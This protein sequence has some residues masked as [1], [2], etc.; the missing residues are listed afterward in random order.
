MDTARKTIHNLT[1]ENRKKL[2]LDGVED[3]I[4][5]DDASVLLDTVMG[6]LTINGSSLRIQELC[7]EKGNVSLEGDI[8]EILYSDTQVKK[9]GFFG[10]LFR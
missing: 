2:V 10:K 7:L 6:Q 1:L 9:S 5:F 3:V 8:D 4:S